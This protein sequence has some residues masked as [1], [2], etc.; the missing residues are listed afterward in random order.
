MSNLPFLLWITAADLTESSWETVEATM[1]MPRSQCAS[2][3][4][5][6][7]L[8][9]FG[10]ANKG[11]NE[12][13][14]AEVFGDGTMKMLPERMPTARRGCVAVVVDDRIV[15]IGGLD[16]GSDANYS[17]SEDLEDSDEDYDNPL[18]CVEAM[19]LE[20]M[21][22]STLS[23]MK[24]AR[25][26]CCAGVVGGFVIVAGGFDESEELS[27]AE[28]YNPS[29]QH[30]MD[31]PDMNFPHYHGAMAVV[32]KKAYV[33]GGREQKSVEVF[34]LET[35]TWTTLPPMS[36]ER[37]GCAAVAVGN[38]IVVVG[39]GSDIVEIFDVE[40]HTWSRLQNLP[41]AREYC[42][43]GL[44]GN[45]ILVV[46]GQNKKGHRLDT[47]VSL[48]VEDPIEPVPRLPDFPD[49][50]EL[51][52][53]ERKAE[54]EKWVSQVAALKR[55]YLVKIEADSV[56]FHK[57]YSTNKKSQETK[58]EARKQALTTEYEAK[59]EALE[60]E[61]AN[62]K[63]G[64]EAWYGEKMNKLEHTSDV[65]SDKI[66]AKIEDAKDQIRQLEK[67]LAG[68]KR[69]STE[70]DNEDQD[71]QHDLQSLL[72]C[73]I[74]KDTM[75]DPVFAADGHT[76]ER[77]AIEGLFAKDPRGRVL[78]PVTNEPLPNRNLIP[79]VAVQTMASHYAEK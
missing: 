50:L 2:T 33:F 25:H 49:I 8:F 42:A 54:L 11:G 1:K 51:E 6:N 76:Y 48:N 24:T 4:V 71:T 78:S 5:G 43:A 47:I 45:R 61:I 10:G 3:V 9:I 63:K 20:T 68:T 72:R 16:G 60:T 32:G 62:E 30:W 29:I 40:T 69:K 15:V 14:S 35:H 22:W 79:N 41:E 64:L 19:D 55:E 70:D 26:G 12:T 53:K 28:L 21:N 67:R 7:R 52:R 34:D 58:H 44:V 37:E 13:P 56:R 73:P 38:F 59:K 66:D 18:D 23:S 74:T 36:I 57:K 46:G 39:G 75:V 27:S 77:S 17:D 31:L 65:W